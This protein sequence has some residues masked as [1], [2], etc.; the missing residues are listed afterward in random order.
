MANAS[1][2]VLLMIAA[3]AAF[4]VQ[5]GFARHLASTYNTLMMFM[6]RY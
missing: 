4:A 3:V 2:G 6:R 5:D 1:K